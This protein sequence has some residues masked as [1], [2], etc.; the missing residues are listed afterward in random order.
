MNVIIVTS[1]AGTRHV[2]DLGELTLAQMSD[3]E[4][5]MAKLKSD[6]NIR[7]YLI[8]GSESSTFAEVMSWASQF[9]PARQYT[10]SE[11][12][13]QTADDYAPAERRKNPD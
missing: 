13:I 12:F 11:L 4:S 3:F 5:F 1:L 8:T 10:R 9:V 6:R 7:D 2:R